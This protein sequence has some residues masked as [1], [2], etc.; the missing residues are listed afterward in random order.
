M[1]E[2]ELIEAASFANTAIRDSAMNVVTV[3]F[4]YVVC[5]YLAGARLTRTAAYSVS[6]IYSLFLLGPFFGVALNSVIVVTIQEN[7]N[8]SYPNGVY[9]TQTVDA[10]VVLL[11]ALTPLLVAWISSLIYMHM[12]I[13]KQD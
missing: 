10:I 11:I 7:Y 5:S 9:Y 12:H 2:F 8:S 3:F 4:A 6:I 13:R 1:T